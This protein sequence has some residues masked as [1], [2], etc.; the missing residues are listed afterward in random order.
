MTHTRLIEMANNRAWGDKSWGVRHITA[1]ERDRHPI[2]D[3]IVAL[4]MYADG[5]QEEFRNPLGE[6]GVLGPAWRQAVTGVRQL[7]NGNLGQL[8]A[9]TLDRMLVGMLEKEGFDADRD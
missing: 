8:D 3:M 2:R 9:G 1:W 5:H 6:D 4:A 7:L